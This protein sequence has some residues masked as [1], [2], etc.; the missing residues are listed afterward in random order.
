MTFSRDDYLGALASGQLRYLG[1]TPAAI[2]V[3]LYDGVAVLRY[4]AEMEVE[5]GGN[6]LPQMSCWHT[7]VYEKF[8]EVW[9]VVW[10]QATIIQ[11]GNG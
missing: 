7:D 9:M 3:R 8:D 1:W 2:D 5:F 4:R 6:V 11:Q 10:S